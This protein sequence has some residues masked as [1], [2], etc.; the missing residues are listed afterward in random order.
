MTPGA[1]T[2]TVWDEGDPGRAGDRTSLAWIRTGLLP[3]AAGG[4]VLRFPG[5]ESVT[6][7]EVLG[8]AYMALGAFIWIAGRVRFSPSRLVDPPRPAPRLLAA[9]SGCVALLTV[10]T[11]VLLLV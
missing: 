2:T 4:A 8:A 1:G 5:F 7:H 11:I 9:L 3:I 10:A 6:G